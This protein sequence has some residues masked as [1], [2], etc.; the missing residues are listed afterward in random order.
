[1][2]RKFNEIWDI[3]WLYSGDEKGN[4][5]MI[6][7]RLL[8][9]L[10]GSGKYII[11]QIIWQL[12]S[13]LVQIMIAWNVTNLIS[14]VWHHTLTNADMIQVAMSIF[15]GVA[16]RYICDLLYTRAS[17]YASVDVK[18]V[19]RGQI[20]E[21]LL[22][23]GLSYREQIRTSEIVQMVGEGVEQLETY[24]S[25]Y[26]SQ[27][28]YALFAPV[29][30]FIVISQISVKTAWYLLVAVFLIPIVIM[31][32]MII[33]KKLLSHYFEIYYGLGDSFLEK[34]QGMTTLKIYQADQT[35]ADDMDKES[36]KFR[37]ITMKVLMMQLNSTSM[38]DIIAYGGATVGMISALVLFSKGEISL[39]GVLMILFLAAEFFLPMRL[40]GSL[41][42]IGMNGIKASDR[43]FALLDLPEQT[44]GTKEITGDKLQIQIKNLSFSYDDK[45]EILHGIDMDIQPKSFVSI[46]GVSGSGKSTIAGILMGL[47]PKYHGVI[48]INQDEHGDLSSQSIMSHIT[49]VSHNSWLFEGTVKE[50]LLMGNALATDEQMED[51]LKKVNLLAFVNSQD[52][53]NTRIETNGSNFSGGQ[54]QRL[55]LA[56]ALLHNTPMYI[57]DEATSN[58]DA[59][60]EE[61]IMQV[62]RNLSKEKTVILISHRLANVVD[63][64]CIY[65]LQNGTIVES[66]THHE[67]METRGVYQNLFTKQMN[68]ERYSHGKEAL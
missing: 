56:R 25:R 1:M 21:K 57:F 24:F 50:N 51:A 11:Y 36:E 9:L 29:I 53:L 40:L 33:A 44:R 27:F 8:R 47:N 32:V 31:L 5:C 64:D 16:I 12:V 18:R 30:L 35:A 14:L 52:G 67:L 54:K 55:A 6:K 23:L 39:T 60:S 2:N 58:I 66:G 62:I 22:R 65:L 41:F 15:L 19:L 61:I 3:E 34:L 38:M 10:K 7:T 46:V 63:S 13:L 4:E 20:Y 42:H 26:L 49:M 28:F 43:I 17:F 45:R 68:L 37:K 48:K 59:S